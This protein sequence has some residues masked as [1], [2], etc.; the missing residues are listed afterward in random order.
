MTT[1]V[2]QQLQREELVYVARQV[3]V[4]EK[5]MRADDEEMIAQLLRPLEKA[6]A[7]AKAAAAAEKVAADKAAA[8]RAATEKEAA[9]ML[10]AEVRLRAE[11]W[12]SFS[13]F[14]R[15]DADTPGS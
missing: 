3:D 9:M 6:G 7:A 1:Q 2:L 8:E 12:P 13:Q 5:E 14:S 15:F 4:F 11:A 10:R